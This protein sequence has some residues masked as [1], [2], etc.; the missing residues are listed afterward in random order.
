MT[1]T[2][3]LPAVSVIVPAY[4]VTRF[5]ADTLDSL[6]TQTFRDFETIVVNDGCPDSANLER[7]LE[8]YR[9]EIIYIRQEN[10]GLAGARNTAIRAARAPLIALLDSDDAWEPDYLQ[11]QTGFLTE[12]PQTDVVSPNAL[13][14]GET[15]FPGKTM[16]DL[17]PPRGEVSFRSLVAR[18]NHIFVGVT[19]RR[20]AI[21]RAGLFDP[22]LRSAE[23]LDLWLRMAHGGAR[24][25]YHNRPLV[26][27]RARPDSLSNDPIWIITH[28]LQVYRKLSGTLDLNAEDRASLEAAIR[29]EEATRE[30][31]L[32]KKALYAGRNQ[33]AQERLGQA[34]RVLRSRK[35]SIALLVMRIAPGLLHK[36]VHWRSP[37]E[38]TFLH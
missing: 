25:A 31:Y 32:G 1:A 11:V 5:I 14:V 16:A 19:A 34:N 36:L 2:S 4:N 15:L 29:H 6:R 17:F 13:F 37:T 7:V 26:R 28:V 38:Y 24:F 10:Q 27:Y 33:E 12:H 30:F 22:E 35:V 21:L 9:G 3:S 23:D 18:E 20:E 8:P